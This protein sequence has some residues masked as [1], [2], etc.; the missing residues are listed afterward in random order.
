MRTL[1]K[2]R[3]ER[4]RYEENLHRQLRRQQMISENLLQKQRKEH[5][6][7]EWWKKHEQM[8]EEEQKMIKA[9]IDAGW[10]VGRL[11]GRDRGLER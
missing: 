7:R 9:F 6:Q 2:Q 11:G 8:L 4:E 1:L 10:T 5:E 3:K